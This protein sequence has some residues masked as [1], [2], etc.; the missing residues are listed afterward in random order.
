MFSHTWWDDINPNPRHTHTYT[1]ELLWDF[2]R[3]SFSAITGKTR[4]FTIA[5]PCLWKWMSSLQSVL[6]RF[7]LQSSQSVTNAAD[8]FFIAPIISE[9]KKPKQKKTGSWL[10]YV[11]FHKWKCFCIYAL[12]FSLVCPIMI[13]Q[14][15]VIEWFVPTWLLKKE[16]PCVRLKSF[17]YRM[18]FLWSIWTSILTYILSRQPDTIATKTTGLWK[19]CKLWYVD[20]NRSL[21]LN[22][23]KRCLDAGS[24]IQVRKSQKAHSIQ[25]NSI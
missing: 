5:N 18:N 7:D 20:S 19:K 8:T 17:N 22:Q 12:Y 11:N 24:V 2:W 21:L 9:P 6:P 16:F 23:T 3:M 1:L 25:P 13:E 14:N 4:N 10:V 15:D